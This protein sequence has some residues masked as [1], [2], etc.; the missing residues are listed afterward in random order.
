MVEK[1]K[2]EEEEEEKKLTFK[3]PMQLCDFFNSG[4]FISFS[5]VSSEAIFF[6]IPKTQFSSASVLR[7]RFL[8]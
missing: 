3:E 5:S 4:A 2:K 1:E 8:L 7:D 6:L